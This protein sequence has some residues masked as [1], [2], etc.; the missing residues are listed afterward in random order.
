MKPA[1]N[2]TTLI[3]KRTWLKVFLWGLGLL[4]FL[5]ALLFGAFYIW[6]S[7]GNFDISKEKLT[8]TLSCGD[9]RLLYYTTKNGKGHVDYADKSG[10]VYAQY[11]LNKLTEAD[12]IWDADCKGIRIGTG[13]YATRI[14]IPK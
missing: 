7:S 1:I 3:K 4:I 6:L 13:D 2:L 5:M 10:K 12:P 8:K 9:Y 11:P 14:E